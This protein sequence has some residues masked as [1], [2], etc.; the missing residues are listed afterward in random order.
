M[1]GAPVRCADNIE[2]TG[3]LKM[4][5]CWSPAGSKQ[6]VHLLSPSDDGQ[7]LAAANTGCEVH[8]YNLQKL[9]VGF[10]FLYKIYFR[11]ISN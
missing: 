10:S 9:K 1:I 3:F 6:P 2:L 5:L 8:V 7:W 11:D 4:T